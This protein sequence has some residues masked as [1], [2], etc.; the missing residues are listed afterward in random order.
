MKTNDYQGTAELPTPGKRREIPGAHIPEGLP[1]HFF[2]EE[3][4]LDLRGVTAKEAW[5]F[6]DINGI[7]LPVIQR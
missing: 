5:K 3:G 6:F 7:H 4:D 1:D 2:N